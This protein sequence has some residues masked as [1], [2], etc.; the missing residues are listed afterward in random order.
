MLIL[1][2]MDT[3]WQNEGLRAS[4]NW[5]SQMSYE[6]VASLLRTQSVWAVLMCLCSICA[7]YNGPLEAAHDHIDDDGYDMAE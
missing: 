6:A 1:T 4:P 2:T 3:I 7:E 5:T